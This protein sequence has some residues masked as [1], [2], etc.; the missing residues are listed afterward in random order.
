MNEFLGEVIIEDVTVIHPNETIELNDLSFLSKGQETKK[1]L[2]LSSDM[3]TAEVNGNINFDKV[4]ED[5]SFMTSVYAP[6]LIDSNR[7]NN[8][9]E[10][11]TYDITIRFNDFDKFSSLFIP[12]LS[13]SKGSIMELDFNSKDTVFSLNTKSD[14]FRIKDNVFGNIEIR[15][16]KN[17]K[18][19]SFELLAEIDNYSL[20]NQFNIEN[21]QTAFELNENR[22]SS[23]LFYQGEDSTNYGKIRLQS[24]V[25]S[26][27]HIITEI[28]ELV[29]GSNENDI[30]ELGEGA[31][32]NFK[33]NKLNCSHFFFNK[34][35][36]RTKAKRHCRFQRNR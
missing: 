8:Y 10:D 2:H 6:N 7:F 17:K 11:H 32:I 5:F 21:I 30:W 28:E 27:D 34:S 31:E 3:L 29:L 18:S 16:K 13:I 1:E 33:E 12:D 25:H 24:K 15:G 26:S 23:N 9:K 36:T 20:S 22:L 4:M 19:N 35:T 14:K